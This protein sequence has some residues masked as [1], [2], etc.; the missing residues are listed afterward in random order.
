VSKDQAVNALSSGQRHGSN[1]LTGACRLALARRPTYQPLD[2]TISQ[3][4]PFG[5][6]LFATRAL[7]S[8]KAQP[9]G[10]FVLPRPYSPQTRS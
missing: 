7:L 9:I 5:I 10:Y 8:G 1:R 3:K 4:S 2:V 6:D